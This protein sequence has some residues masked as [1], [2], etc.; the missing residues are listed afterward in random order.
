M[1][2]LIREGQTRQLRDIRSTASREGMPTLEQSL[3]ALA[4][5]GT[6]EHATATGASLYPHEVQAARR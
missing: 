5:A 2:N 1:R 4:S 6:I 3:T